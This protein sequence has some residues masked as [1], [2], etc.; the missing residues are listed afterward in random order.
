[1]KIIKLTLVGKLTKK[2]EGYINENH[3]IFFH[4]SPF[5]GTRI[6]LTSTDSSYIDVKE[7]VDKVMKLLVQ[8]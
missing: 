7:S 2:Q 1:M 8:E 4:E 6:Y 3:I 5:A